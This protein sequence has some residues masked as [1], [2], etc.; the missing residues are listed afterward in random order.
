MP[1]SPNMFH[2][3][4]QRPRSYQVPEKIQDRVEHKVAKICSRG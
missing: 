2:S 3:F 1:L 4:H